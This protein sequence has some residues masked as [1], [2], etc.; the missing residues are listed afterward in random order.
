MFS[1][2]GSMLKRV[3]YLHGISEIGGAEKELLRLLERIDRS[4]FDPAV[5][6]PSDGPLIGE[7]ER[8]DVP[9]YPMRLP[10]W[11]KVRE[12][13]AIPRAVRA[14]ARLLKELHVDLVHVNDYWWGPIGDLASKASGIP[15]VVHI[16]QEI[17]PRR[18]KQY[19]LEKPRK[20]IAMSGSIRNVAVNA[21]V[22]PDRVEVL[23]SGIDP[24][25]TA[26][27]VDR[28]RIREKHRLS[29]KQPVIGTVANL[30][31]RKGYEYL[32]EATAR[33]AGKI[34]DL[35][36]LIVGEGDRRYGEA[37]MELTRERSLEERVTFAGFQEEV[38]AYLAAMDLFVLPSVM[39]GFG[40]VLLE[41]MAAG[42]AVVATA[43]G[44]IP[45]VIEDRVT[46]FLVPPRDPAALAEKILFLLDHPEVRE[47]MGEAGRIRV[48]E[49]FSVDRMVDELERLYGELV[50]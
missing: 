45:E 21:G 19:R 4:R 5:V 38:S 10:A 12:L 20:L 43:V 39:E 15:C 8:L 36:C 26:G 47:E 24:P 46:G 7:V 22:G 41:A 50:G 25:R 49:R 27:E 29:E 48:A 40:I 11:R 13:P 35:H 1:R 37:L 44:G 28:R 42:R 33:I 2:R 6:C 31:P 18:V 23:Y 32:I 3:L 17:E 30:F 34:P 9:V 14:L 16:R